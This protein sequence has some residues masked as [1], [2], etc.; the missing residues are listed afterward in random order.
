LNVTSSRDCQTK[1]AICLSLR[2]YHSFLGFP[3]N[4]SIS[5]IMPWCISCWIIANWQTPLKKIEKGAIMD[6]CENRRKIYVGMMAVALLATV[7][8]AGG[9]L[10][11]R[12]NG[13]GMGTLGG[14]GAG[15]MI[16]D[17]LQGQE[18][19]NQQQYQQMRS[20]RRKIYAK[21][22]GV[23]QVN[24]S[25]TV[26]ELTN[27]TAP[28]ASSTT[29]TLASSV[30]VNNSANIPLDDDVDVTLTFDTEIWDDDIF[31]STVSNPSR[32][33]FGINENGKTCN[34]QGHARFDANPKGHRTLRIVLNGTDFIGQLSVPASASPNTTTLSV[35]TTWRV[36]TNDYVELFA[37]QNSGGSLNI[38]TPLLPPAFMATCQ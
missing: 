18:I 9:P 6:W 38:I 17:Q 13:A 3:K 21:A 26:T 32:I 31:H 7:G 23:Y 1:M 36:A 5:S 10:S 34:I 4:F 33:T 2:S 35:S 15:E 28:L 8:C 37:H 29:A 11:T 22:D 19:K 20:G 14:A 12:E 27:A 25:G 24:S 30:R 16:G